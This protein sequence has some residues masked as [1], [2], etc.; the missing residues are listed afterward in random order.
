M[1]EPSRA[2]PKATPL[3]GEINTL[4]FSTPIAPGLKAIRSA[5]PS[6]L[7]SSTTNAA[8]GYLLRR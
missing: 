6:P 7:A 3:D 2:A 8:R 1:A 4:P 5:F